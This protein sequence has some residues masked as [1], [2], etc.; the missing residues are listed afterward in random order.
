MTGYEGLR[1]RLARES[2]ILIAICTLDLATTLLFIHEHGAGEGNPVMGYYLRY[3]VGVFIMVKLTLIALP[4]FIAEWSK[5]YR[6]HFVKMALRATIAS[7]VGA[8]LLGIALINL[9]PWAGELARMAATPPSQ[10]SIS[11]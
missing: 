8:Y 6:P 3:G 2:L 5:Q 4:V 1:M 9:T 7:Y 10:S 11:R